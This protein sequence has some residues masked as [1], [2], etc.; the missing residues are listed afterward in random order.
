MPDRV[1]DDTYGFR[2]FLLNRGIDREAVN[3]CSTV[4]Q[5]HALG[6]SSKVFR[7]ERESVLP[8]VLP[9]R[10]ELSDEEEQKHAVMELI[11]QDTHNE[12]K[13][14][15][16]VMARAQL[17]EHK[18]EEQDPEE[19]LPV[20]PVQVQGRFDHDTAGPDQR[21]L[22]VAPESAT[23]SVKGLAEWLTAP[24]NSDRD[25]HRAIFRCVQHVICVHWPSH[26][27]ID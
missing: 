16:R 22:M 27:C 3:G 6:C 5:L 2:Q 20:A 14:V 23:S 15:E 21:A 12:G 1:A 25:K 11:E 19:E 4:G 10:T 8:D 26:V 24:F 17:K 18:H 13:A 9:G 7:I